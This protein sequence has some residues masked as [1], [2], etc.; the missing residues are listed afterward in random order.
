MQ[1]FTISCAAMRK[2]NVI[3]QHIF[4]L[5]VGASSWFAKTPFILETRFNGSY[6]D[7]CRFLMTFGTK[8]SSLVPFDGHLHP[9]MTCHGIGTSFILFQSENKYLRYDLSTRS[10]VTLNTPILSKPS[11]SCRVLGQYLLCDDFNLETK[12]LS[13]YV[14][15]LKEDKLF[16]QYENAVNCQREAGLV[17]RFTTRCAFSLQ[18]TM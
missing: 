1:K 15:D 14:Y 8:F 11:S 10:F 7:A 9:E 5:T 12:Y 17:S 16:L 4:H 6:Y 13:L 3:W 2:S 18:C